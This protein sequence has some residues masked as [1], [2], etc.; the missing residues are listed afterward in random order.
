MRLLPL[1]LLGPEP[2]EVA[3]R[4]EL[5]HAR[6]LLARNRQCS[7]QRDLG[8]SGIITR[9]SP[10][11]GGRQPMQLGDSQPLACALGAREPLARCCHRG[12]HLPEPQARVSH[13]HI[14]IGMPWDH[15]AGWLLHQEAGGYSARFDGS[16]YRPTSHEGGIICAPDAASW[17]ALHET[18]FRAS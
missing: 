12:L 13:E 16:P 5:P 1:A 14:V 6:A 11:A 10:M 3:A 8:G 7:M 18:L 9:T 17:H 15:A 2:G 4:P